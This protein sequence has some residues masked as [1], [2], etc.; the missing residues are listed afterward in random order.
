[1]R[2]AGRTRRWLGGVVLLV[3][4]LYAG[5][6]LLFLARLDRAPPADARADGGVVLTG[7]PGRIEA[8]I[9]LLREGRVKRVLISGVNPDVT[10][11]DLARANG[12]EPAFAACCV[13]LDFGAL[14]TRGNAREAARWARAQ[15]FASLIV[16]TNDNHM[17]RA[18][19]LIERALPGVAITPYPVAAGTGLWGL[20]KEYAKHLW[21]L[22][23][24]PVE[25]KDA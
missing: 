6:F 19:H 20:V 18:L 23:A 13:D 9:G 11:D 2:G 7:G 24:P 5:G 4:L 12:I 3:L 16:V 25:V 21:T 14:D 15:G 17:P 10:L 22:L 1:M 8:A